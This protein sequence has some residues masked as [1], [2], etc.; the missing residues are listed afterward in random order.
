MPLLLE[1]VYTRWFLTASCVIK[2]AITWYWVTSRMTSKTR[3][4]WNTR[5]SII[6]HKWTNS[7]FILQAACHFIY[8]DKV[9]LG[10]FCFSR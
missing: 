5:P 8:C 4:E 1:R 7:P 2:F 3:S 6:L 9:V 10:S